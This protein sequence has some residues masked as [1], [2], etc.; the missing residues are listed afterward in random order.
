[1]QQG[2]PEDTRVTGPGHRL[3]LPSPHTR[4][5]GPAHVILTA[6]FVV[7]LLMAPISQVKRPKHRQVLTHLRSPS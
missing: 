5:A 4:P 6:P 7:G 2:G 1:M 3:L